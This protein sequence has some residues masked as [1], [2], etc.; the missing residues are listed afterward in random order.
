MPQIQAM[1]QN[2]PLPYTV[3]YDKN[4]D[5][6]KAFGGVRMTPTHFLISPNGHIVWNNIGTVDRETLQALI[7]PFLT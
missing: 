1:T 4:G 3:V 5:Y 6:A 2:K 7:E